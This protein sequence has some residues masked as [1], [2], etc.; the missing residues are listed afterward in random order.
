VGYE[1]VF[2]AAAQ[3]KPHH[4]TSRSIGAVAYRDADLAEAVTGGAA[5]PLVLREKAADELVQASLLGVVTGVQGLAC[6]T[7][8]RHTGVTSLMSATFHW[9]VSHTSP[10]APVGEAPGSGA[11]PDSSPQRHS[12]R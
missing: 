8:V 7:V 2:D 3:R 4:V 1:P 10:V 9:L 5:A 12:G 6:Q 11:A